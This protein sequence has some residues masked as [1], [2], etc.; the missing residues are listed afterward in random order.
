MDSKSNLRGFYDEVRNSLLDI[1]IS[2]KLLN[3]IDIIEL[4]HREL[5]KDANEKIRNIIEKGGLEFY[6]EAENKK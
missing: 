2:A 4:I 6:V 1:K 3:D 5:N